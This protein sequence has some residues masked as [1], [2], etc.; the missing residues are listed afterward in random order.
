MSNDDPIAYFIT[1]TVYGT[2]LQGDDRWWRK[3]QEGSSAPQPK[4]EQWHRDRLNHEVILLSDQQREMVEAE[5]IRL[6]EYR[7][8]HIW[9]AN[10]RSNHVHVVLSTTDHSSK[11]VLGQ[12]KANCTR[13]LCQKFPVFVDRPIWSVGGDRKN[14]FTEFDLN[15]TT[16]YVS[17]AQDRMDRGK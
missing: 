14:L 1:W 10:P 2:F 5:I 8:W 4:L 11:Q 6:A 3:R 17:G 7:A 9:A 12:M 15:Q 13:V 16:I